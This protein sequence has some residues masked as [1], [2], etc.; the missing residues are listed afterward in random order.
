MEE[1]EYEDKIALIAYKP[2]ND[3]TDEERRLRGIEGGRCKKSFLYWL[4]YAKIAD[5]PTLDNIGGIIKF[6][7]WE[8]LKKVVASLLTQKLITV[9]KARQIGL[10]W[11][12]AAYALWFAMSHQAAN[13]M[14][15]SKGEAEAIELLA[16]CRRLYL[17]LPDFMKLKVNP[18]SAT[19]MGF[20]VMMSSIKAWKSV[21]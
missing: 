8:H 12:M 1:Q 20:P 13:I 14:L 15:F 11:L 21:V 5:P 3:V 16:K 6:E 19:E 2:E 4:G 18:D 9:C 10:S 7:L 17:Q